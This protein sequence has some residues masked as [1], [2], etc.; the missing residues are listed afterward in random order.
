[1]YRAVLRIFPRIVLDCTSFLEWI[2]S[3]WDHSLDLIHKCPLR[4]LFPTVSLEEAYSLAFT[5]QWSNMTYS[6][7]VRTPVL[8]PIQRGGRVWTEGWTVSAW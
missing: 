5:S 1:M 3:C 4:F 7:E 2:G 6:A 8:G